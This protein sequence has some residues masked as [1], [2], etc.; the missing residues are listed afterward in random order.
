MGKC[1]CSTRGRLRL[2]C[3]GGAGL[4]RAGAGGSPPRP[5]AIF[6]TE[7][8]DASLC[9]AWSPS[10]GCAPDREFARHEGGEVGVDGSHALRRGGA[11]RVDRGGRRGGSGGG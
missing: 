4:Q 3:T 1:S 7:P 11:A 8:R 9:R 5:T 6:A 2:G 10:G